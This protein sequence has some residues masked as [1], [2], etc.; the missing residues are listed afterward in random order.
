MQME[1]FMQSERLT[2][3]LIE[4]FETKCKWDLNDQL[5]Q[6]NWL[7]LMKAEQRARK[8]WV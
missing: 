2:E 4:T 3:I 1:G 6:H 8:K 5:K 7:Q